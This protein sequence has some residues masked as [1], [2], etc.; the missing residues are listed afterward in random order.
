[1]RNSR[2]R[3]ATERLIGQL[4]SLFRQNNVPVFGVA[5][6]SSLENE[7]TGYRPSDILALARSVITVGLPVPKGIFLSG[8]NPEAMYWRAANVYYRHIDALLM[9]AASIIEEKDEIAIPIYGCFPYEIKAKGDFRGYLNLVG[10]G[11]ATGIG[12]IGKNGLLFSSRYGPRLILG[13]IVTTAPLPANSPPAKVEKGCPDNCAVC[14]EQCPVGA[15]DRDGQVNG[16]ECVKFSSKSPLFSHF[17]RMGGVATDEMQ[18]LNHVTA[19]DDHSWY[20]CIKCVS[21]CPHM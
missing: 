18:V 5:E 10:M 7:T 1:M 16:L 2:K 6:A 13:G 8:R 3:P 19:V 21:T 20:Q 14:R 11:E 9:R 17:M 15:I 4:R 12:K